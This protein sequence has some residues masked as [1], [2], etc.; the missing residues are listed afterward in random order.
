MCKT[1]TTLTCGDGVTTA[2]EQCDN[3]A[4]NSNTAAGANACT[5]LCR[6]PQCGDTLKQDHEEC[7]RGAMN[8]NNPP[9]NTMACNTMC[10]N[11]HPR[12][13]DMVRQAPQEDCDSGP[14]NTNTPPAYN[15]Q[16][17]NTSCKTVHPRCGDEMVQPAGME[18]C[19]EG[20]RNSNA[21]PPYNQRRCNNS[22]K[23]V[24]PRCGD[25]VVQ[26]A[27]GEEC[28]RGGA[29]TN[30]PPSYNQMACNRSCKTVHPRCGD[31]MRQPANEECDDGAANGMPGRCQSNCRN[32]AAQ[33]TPKKI[34]VASVS[35]GGCGSACLED[36][37]TSS[38]EVLISCRPNAPAAGPPQFRLAG[39]TTSLT[40]M[41]LGGSAEGA[42]QLTLSVV[43]SYAV[44]CDRAGGGTFQLA[45]QANQTIPDE[46]AERSGGIKINIRNTMD[47][48]AAMPSC[49]RLQFAVVDANVRPAP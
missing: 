21:A 15:Q 25:E 12:C 23:V 45:A 3:G 36:I 47:G 42:T 39:E 10:K 6:R 27:A 4:M 20:T 22:C 9:Y 18:E 1:L 48:T 31:G 8:T 33:P 46:C 28:D 35:P 26:Q 44:T 13:G 29:N 34:H 38:G 2:P 7:D 11:I 17:C 19:D 37:N 30:D 5:T 24:H 14:A 32:A 40:F 16:N 49:L 43:G 41:P